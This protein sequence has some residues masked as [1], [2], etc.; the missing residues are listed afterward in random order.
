MAIDFSPS[1]M[2]EEL[3]LVRDTAIRFIDSEMAPQDEAARKRGHVGHAL[4]RRAGE[5]GLLCADIPEQYGG[6]GGDF[7][8]EAVFYE[9][10]ARRSLTGMNASVHS[11]VAHYLLNHGTEAQKQR[12]LPPMARGELVGAIAMTEPGAGSDLQGIRTTAARNDAGYLLNGAKTFITNGYLAGLV[13]V[14]ARTDPAQ[15]A[16]GMSI[17]IVET[18]E[19]PGYSVGRLL[20]KI[21]MKAQDTTELFFDNVQLGPDAVLGG[22]EGRGFYQLMGDLPYER[23]MIGVSAVAAM[24]GAYEATL[25]YTREREAF[26]QP[27]ADFQNT[28]FKLAEIATSVKVAR[29]FV[30]RCVEDLVAGRLDTASASM[31]KYWTSDLQNR[32]IDDCLQLFGGYGYMNEYLIGRMYVDARIQRIYG[33]ANE[34]MKEVIARAL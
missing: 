31:V 24:E 14:V 2:N 15:K 33:G 19:R 32:V 11:I 28:R 18:A 13:L 8:H 5:L 30:D 10:M 3:A 29:V 16:K 20:D 27:L 4:W 17:M 12:Y 7:R 34:I 23:T 21:G 1:W 26:G 9:E 6:G 25:R 22:D